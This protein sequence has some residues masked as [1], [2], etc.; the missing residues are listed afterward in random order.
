MDRT[1]ADVPGTV[2]LAAVDA[3]YRMRDDR[4]LELVEWQGSAV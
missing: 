1:P 3:P 2:T 4:R